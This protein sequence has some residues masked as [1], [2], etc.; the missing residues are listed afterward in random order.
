MCSLVRKVYPDVKYLMNVDGG[1]SS[2]LS[3]SKDGV[4]KEISYPATSIGNVA[5]MIRNVS[6]ILMI[7]VD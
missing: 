6:T 4:L 5:G 3:I 1:A 7:G 2:V